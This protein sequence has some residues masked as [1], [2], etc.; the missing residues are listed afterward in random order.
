RRSPRS[1]TVEL[2]ADALGLDELERAP[3]LA[4]ARAS[5]AVPSSGRTAVVE[6]GTPSATSASAWLPMAQPT[7][8]VD[9]HDELDTILQRLTVE[10]VRLLTLTGPAGVGKTRL[11]LTAASRLAAQLPER[12]ADG[13]VVV[14]LSPV[15]DPE[16]VLGVIARAFGFIDTGMPP[17][18]QRFTTFLK[19]RAQL[20]VLDNFEQV[21]P[22][23]ATLATLLA[24]C[25]RLALLVTSRVSLHLRWEQTFRIAPFPVPDV[26]GGVLPPLDELLAMPAVALFVSRAQA[27]RA[28]FEVTPAQAPLVAQLVTQLDGLPLALKLAAAR[29]DVLPLTTMVQRVGDRLRLLRWDAQDLPERQRSLEAALGW[30]YDLLTD[31]EQRLF[32]C[33]GVFVGRV[34]LDAIAA[35][36]A[37]I[38]A[39]AGSPHEDTVGNTGK[40]LRGLLSLAE[41]SLVLPLPE[42]PGQEE[43]V[44]EE[45]ED[46]EPAFGMLETMRAYAEERLA[47]A[48]ELAAARRA[49]A[50]YF[51]ALAERAH[52]ELRGRDQRAW[53]FR[54]EREQTVLRL[55]AEGLSSKAIGERLS[56]SPSTINQHMKSIFNKLGVDTR[57]QAVAEAANR[58][59]L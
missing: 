51:L 2:L 12:F 31:Q 44:G 55:V 43:S 32:R 45:D 6:R 33:L 27:H 24:G 1:T 35:V 3:F 47:A 48:G 14:D 40:A 39:S 22:A 10:G 30:S 4:A 58:R 38:D 56:F 5:G 59:V 52:P 37:G 29:M 8:L 42:H 25:P 9:R 54:L 7:P 16:Q 26:S 13:V 53:L 28:D 17:L 34:Y 49:H 18:P 23:A 11:A 50:H 15:R 41:K 46:T 20:V 57:A 36:V 21:L 19:E